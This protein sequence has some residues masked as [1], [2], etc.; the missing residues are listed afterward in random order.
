MARL[1]IHDEFLAAYDAFADAIFRHCY[2]RVSDR[3]RAKDLMQE[4]F[5]RAWKYIAEGK[6][7]D[8]VRA[9][10]YRVANN[11][12]VDESR[13]KKGV[14][15]DQLSEVGFDPKDPNMGSDAVEAKMDAERILAFVE[16][17]ASPYRE[18]LVMR[19]VDGFSVK[20]I[21]DILGETANTVSVRIH[22]GVKML[23]NFV[24]FHG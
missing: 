11:L 22:R 3:D 16:R 18:A 23:K 19:Y 20:E 6:T 7:V 15:L 2:M 13:K 12:I 5:T 17:V 24:S 1:D 8:N 14:S 4:T 21:A 10:L 9:F